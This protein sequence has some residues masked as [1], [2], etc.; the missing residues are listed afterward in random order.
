MIGQG[1]VSRRTWLLA[2]LGVALSAVFIALIRAGLGEASGADALVANLPSLLTAGIGGGVAL[3]AALQF[4][5]GERLRRQ[6]L[7]I[8]LGTLALFAGDA[9]YAYLEV[10][11]KQEV[12][13]P[14]IADLFYLASFPL[15]GAAVLMALLSFR[16]SLR[17]G[18]PLAV[19]A[20]VTA[21]ATAALWTS[22]F[23]PVLA[24]AE[25]TTLERTLGVFYPIGDFWLLLFPAL[26]LAIALSRLAGGRLAWPWWAVVAGFALISVAD[27]LFALAESGGTYSS[28]SFIDLGWWLGYTAIAV[29]ASLVVDVQKP[30][31]TG[32]RS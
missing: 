24:D 26:A 7:L 9:T 15:L 13:F 2:G 16:R 4:E 5:R 3:W 18:V 28:G 22:V 21:L 19:A 12:P 6:W 32:G 30:R 23:Q 20:T 29:G 27:T 14:S 25:A 10:V 31:Q 17:L 1:V 8:G 11:A